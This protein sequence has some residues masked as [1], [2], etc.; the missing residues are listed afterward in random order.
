MAIVAKRH[1]APLPPA[2]TITRDVAKTTVPNMLLCVKETRIIDRN[3]RFL[4]DHLGRRILYCIL[5]SHPFHVCL[6]THSLR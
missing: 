6:R 2:I 1:D 3:A 4:V 5:V